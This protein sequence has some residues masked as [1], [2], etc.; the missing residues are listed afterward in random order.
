MKGKFKETGDW[1]YFEVKTSSAK[2]SIREAMGQIMEYSHYDH[3]STRAKKLF[4]IGPEKPDEK[5]SAYLKKLR[6]MYGL[7]IWFRWYSFQENR[8][9]EEL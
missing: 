1:H 3:M 8:L 7:P 5:D 4:I 2:Q 6:D 9:Y